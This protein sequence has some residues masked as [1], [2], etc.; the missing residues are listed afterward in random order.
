MPKTTVI[1][2]SRNEQYTT[3]TVEDIFAKARG[4][5]EVIVCLEGWWPAEWDKVA[6]KYPGKLITIHHGQPHG[7]RSSI[8]Q[9]AAIASGDF[10]MKTDAHCLFSKGFDEVLKRDCPSKTV[11]VPRRYRLDPEKW[12]II[13][14]GRP[15]VDYEYLTSP[16]TPGGGLKGRVWEQKAVERKDVPI[17][18]LWLFQGSCWWMPRS[19]FYELDLMDEENYGSFFKE[20]LEISLKAWL[21]GGQVLVNKN[22]WYA[23]LHKQKRGYSMPS[24]EERKAHEFSS[25]W[26]TDGT[27]W[28]KQTLPF[29]SLIEK[30]NP[31]DWP[32][33]YYYWQLAKT[34]IE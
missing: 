17:D 24:D 28:G 30:F 34:I 7:M 4:D 11:M 10:L 2:P 5:I 25:L 1:I 8:N 9:A 32:T 29:H 19:Y 26:L 3:K 21:S 12:A 16:S 18:S 23:H 31:P 22:V 33:E 20:A 14:D 27:G 6:D 15:P 13:K